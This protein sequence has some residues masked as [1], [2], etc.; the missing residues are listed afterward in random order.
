MVANGQDGLKLRRRKKNRVGPPQEEFSL[1]A[2]STASQYMYNIS[3]NQYF[4]KTSKV[5]LIGITRVSV[6]RNALPERRNIFSLFL[7]KICENIVFVPD[8]KKNVVFP[9]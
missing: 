7:W 1:I 8:S 3:V 9:L 4:L 2:T 5:Y 6:F